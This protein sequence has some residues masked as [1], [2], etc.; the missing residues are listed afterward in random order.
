MASQDKDP[1]LLEYARF[2]GLSR[3]HQECNPLEELSSLSASLYEDTGSFPEKEDFAKIEA[4]AK[5]PPVERLDVSREALNLLREVTRLQGPVPQFE[6]DSKLDPHRVRN[7]KQ[8]LPL[9]RTDHEADMQDIARRAEVDLAHD[10]LPLEHIEEEEDEGLSWPKKYDNLP[11][12]CLKELQNERLE[13][14]K[15]AFI[16][17]KDV[18]N[19][20]VTC[21][22]QPVFEYERP[23]RQHRGNVRGL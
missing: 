7:L 15:D 6:H 8:E 3:N 12:E 9:L 17:L 22:E 18:M 4:A 13:I 23:S 14:P 21:E 2:H 10:F 5:S 19:F 1:P 20:G 11:E 16:Y